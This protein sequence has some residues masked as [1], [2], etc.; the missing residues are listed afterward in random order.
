MNE[1]FKFKTTYKFN[2]I[3]KETEIIPKKPVQFISLKTLTNP[4]ESITQPSK[5]AFVIIIK[6]LNVL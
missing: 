3:K 1:L 6:G 5:G 2:I 4:E